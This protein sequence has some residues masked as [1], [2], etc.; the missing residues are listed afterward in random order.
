MSGRFAKGQWDPWAS[1]YQ[2]RNLIDQTMSSRPETRNC[3]HASKPKGARKDLP[4]QGGWPRPPSTHPGIA[5]R[6]GDREISP[7][8]RWKLPWKAL[9]PQPFENGAPPPPAVSLLT[10]PSLLPVVVC[11]V[12]TM[13]GFKSYLQEVGVPDTPKGGKTWRA[14]SMQCLLSSCV[15]RSLC[16]ASA[17]CSG[18]SG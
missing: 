13:D 18:C 17:N 5:H 4:G 8:P 12:T 11:P 9:Q 2:E 1:L 6:R 15:L 14:L 3:R 10:L 16:T 7:S